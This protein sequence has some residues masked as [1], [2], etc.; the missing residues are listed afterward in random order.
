VK[1]RNGGPEFLQTAAVENIRLGRFEKP[2]TAPYTQTI[3]YDFGFDESLPA[4][5]GPK[6]A[7]A[8]TKVA[9]DLPDRVTLRTNFPFC[10][11]Q[12]RLKTLE[13]PRWERSLPFRIAF[14]WTHRTKSGLE[15]S[16]PE[17]QNLLR[18]GFTGTGRRA[19]WAMKD[20]NLRP[21]ACEASALTTELIAR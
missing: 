10:G 2:P 4:Y 15:A 20:L 17:W 12:Y 9:S 18:G 11:S 5:R 7:P 14:F 6:S 19:W 13:V 21:L 8:I 16:N 3:A 1:V